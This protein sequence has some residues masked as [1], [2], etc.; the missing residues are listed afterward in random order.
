MATRQDMED[1]TDPAPEQE[2]ASNPAHSLEQLRARE[3]Q[4]TGPGTAARRTLE[5]LADI[6]RLSDDLADLDDYEI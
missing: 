5:A 3:R 6:R 4:R 2:P 1:G